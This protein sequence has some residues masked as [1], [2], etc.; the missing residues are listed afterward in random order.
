MLRSSLTH[1]PNGSTRV[2]V[3]RAEPKIFFGI[4]PSPLLSSEDNFLLIPLRFPSSLRAHAVDAMG[5]RIG[6]ASGSNKCCYSEIALKTASFSSER[7]R[8]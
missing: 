8:F 3:G 1:L 2:P 6:G 5:F 4:D 7:K